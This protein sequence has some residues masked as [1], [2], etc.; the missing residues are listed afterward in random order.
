MVSELAITCQQF[1]A[2]EASLKQHIQ[3]ITLPNP[4]NRR[5]QWVNINAYEKQMGPIPNHSI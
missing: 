2:G 5:E 3:S 4:S 1:F